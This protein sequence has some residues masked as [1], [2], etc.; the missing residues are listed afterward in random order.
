MQTQTASSVLSF[1]TH[2]K[3]AI[4]YCHSAIND[5]KKSVFS[6]VFKLLLPKLEWCYNTTIT[7]HLLVQHVPQTIEIIKET[8]ESDTLLTLSIHQKISLLNEK[9]QEALEAVVDCLL[10]GETFEIVENRE[11]SNDGTKVK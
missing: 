4:L 10:A 8:W 1:F 3:L 5:N 9:N 6:I 11:Y 2:L 7:H